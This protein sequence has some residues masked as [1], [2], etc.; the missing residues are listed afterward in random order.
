MVHRVLEPDAQIFLTGERKDDRMVKGAAT[1]I[2][3]VPLKGR[4]VTDTFRLQRR[5][6]VIKIWPKL[7]RFGAVWAVNQ[8]NRGKFVAFQADAANWH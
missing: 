5:E 2:S 3:K 6:P 1:D 8:R 4:I 7:G